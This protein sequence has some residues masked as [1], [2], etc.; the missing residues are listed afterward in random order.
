MDIPVKNPG[1]ADSHHLDT[2]KAAHLRINAL[3]VDREQPPQTSGG[4]A[5][6]NAQELVTAMNRLMTLIRHAVP[7]DLAA[8]DEWRS[9]L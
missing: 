5:D 2:L 6:A 3:R 7:E 4:V 8:F 1:D 9:R